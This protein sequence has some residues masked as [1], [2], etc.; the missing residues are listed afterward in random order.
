[1]TALEQRRGEPIGAYL[2]LL[3]AGKMSEVK[4]YAVALEAFREAF[5]ALRNARYRN[6]V[7]V[8]IHFKL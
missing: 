7:S 6:V 1:M 2:F 4:A 3:V 8:A 5:A